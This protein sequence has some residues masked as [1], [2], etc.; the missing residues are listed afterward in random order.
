MNQES[1]LREMVSLITLI[2]RPF[3]TYSSHPNVF[4]IETFQRHFLLVSN[5]KNVCQ[6]C[7]NIVRWIVFST[8]NIFESWDG[9]YDSF[10]MPVSTVLWWLPGV[11]LRRILRLFPGSVIKESHDEFCHVH[12]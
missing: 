3:S 5:R 10:H 8:R 6:V 11:L 4:E 12:G 7:L 9:T 2:T 1:M